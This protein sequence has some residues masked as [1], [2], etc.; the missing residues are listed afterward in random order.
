MDSL[1][2]V[3][4]LTPV[5]CFLSL[6]VHDIHSVHSGFSFHFVAY[7]LLSLVHDIHSVHSGFSFYFVAI[8]WSL[9][10]HDIHSVH[11]GFSFHFVAIY[12]SLLVHDIHS[13]HSGFFFYFVAFYWSLR[14]RDIHSLSLSSGPQVKVSVKRLRKYFGAP[15]SFTNRNSGETKQ[16]VIECLPYEDRGFDLKRV[17]LDHGTQVMLAL[18]HYGLGFSSRNF[19]KS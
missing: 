7:Y 11:S 16:S 12:W 13:V 1:C 18:C 14:V 19:Q 9:R 6:L 2:K 10:V 5:T 3:F 17:E 4:F 15:C 8:Y